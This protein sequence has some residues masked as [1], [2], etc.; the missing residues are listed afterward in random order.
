MDEVHFDTGK[1]WN[2]VSMEMTEMRLLPKEKE[3]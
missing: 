3:M 2:E 1:K